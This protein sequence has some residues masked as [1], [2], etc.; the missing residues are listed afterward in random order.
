MSTIIE[1]RIH[2]L[3][4]ANLTHLAL[5]IGNLPIGNPLSPLLPLLIPTDVFVARA[6]LDKD[7]LAV[8]FVPGPAA[9]VDVAVG[10]GAFALGVL[11]AGGAGA[12]EEGAGVGVAGGCDVWVPRSE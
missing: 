1:Q 11:G 5:L 7:A 2:T 9:G 4:I 10:V 8:F 3:S 12:G 6:L